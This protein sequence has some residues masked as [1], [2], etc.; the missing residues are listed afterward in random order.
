MR[1]SRVLSVMTLVLLPTAASPQTP[2]DV[3]PLNGSADFGV[4]G[5]SLSGDGARYERYRDLGDGLFLEKFRLRH[6][7]AGW[8]LVG[9]GDHVGRQDQRFTGSADKAGKFKGWA[10][11]DQIP[12]LLSRTTRTLFAEFAPNVLTIEDGL[13]A[14]AQAQPIAMAVIFRDNAR[15]FETSLR[16]H[17]GEGGFQYFAS[18]ELTLAANVRRSNKDGVIPYGVSFGHSSLVESPAPVQHRLTDLDA[19]AEFVR[20][21]LL[22]RVGSTGSWFHNEFTTFTVDNPFI[23]MD[24]ATASSRSRQSLPPSSAFVTVN[25]QA[26]IQLPRRSRVT[27]YVSAGSLKDTG[28]ALMP[29][30]INTAVSPAALARGTVDGEARTTSTNV[31]FISRPARFM[32]VSIRHRFYDYDNQTPE[33]AMVQRISYDNAP[34]AIVPPVFTEPF[35]V[36]RETL[37]GDVHVN[38]HGSTAGVG[39]TR[40]AEE[41]THRIFE[42]TTDNVFRA[43]FD[44]FSAQRFSLRSKYEHAQ[45]RGTGFDI[46]FLTEAG[47]QP[48]MRHFDV[49]SRDRD[50]V[51]ILGTLIPASIVSIN[52]SI[53][54]G[55]DDYFE[56]LFGLRD[57]QHGVYSFGMDVAPR[58]SVS[59]GGSYSYER[60][61]ALSRSR[62]ANPGVQF[63]D[64]SRNWATDAADRVHSVIVTADLL[65]VVDK[66]DV[67]LLYDFNRA[68]A[69]YNYITGAVADRTL[70]EEAIVPSTLPQPTELPPTLSELH[71]ST[72]DATYAISPR[73]GFGMLWGHERFRVVDFTLD[74]DANP[75]LA[76]GQALL[77]GYLYRPYTANTISA[78]IIYRW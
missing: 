30:T 21:R 13:Q 15:Q 51:T 63:D 47:E 26:S 34:A 75:D 64:P 40:L 19:N 17:T 25:G 1:I 62:Q 3:L 78:R 14:R 42:T 68:R 7:A 72:V 24:S 50:R 37:D 31:S 20:G 57:N 52:A 54:A 5:T 66:L 71:R 39:F 58:E 41:R 12:M 76:R 32:D 6:E 18:P 35:G 49:A 23:A 55:K 77:L 28:D 60:Y 11:W 56:S 16:R 69:R 4:R 46:G 22:L 61:T 29:Q 8:F 53:A 10:S 44:A 48:G 2:A 45:K 73:V 43:T 36:A 27:A 67:Q 65:K 33:F 59:I 9:E 38:L 70:P 74:S